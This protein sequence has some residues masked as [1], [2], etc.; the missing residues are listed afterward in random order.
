LREAGGI[1]LHFA[2]GA[3]HRPDTDLI[4]NQSNDEASTFKPQGFAMVGGNAQPPIRV[5]L[6]YVGIHIK[7]IS[8]C[9]HPTNRVA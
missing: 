3:G 5:N 7:D 2:H 9:P 4:T 6:G 8:F 1:G